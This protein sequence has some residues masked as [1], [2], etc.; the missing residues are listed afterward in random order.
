MELTLTVSLGV[1]QTVLFLGVENDGLRVGSSKVGEGF[2][3]EI[4][5]S[6]LGGRG[7]CGAV[8]RRRN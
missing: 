5:V 6:M 8:G 7:D 1:F 2:M 4:D 3:G